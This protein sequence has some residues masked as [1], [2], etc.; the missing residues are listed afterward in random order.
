M[1]DSETRSVTLETYQ[2]DGCLVV[3][4]V[5]RMDEWMK[6]SEW[7]QDPDAVPEDELRWEAVEAEL[8]EGR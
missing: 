5:E 3:Q 6:S 1:S 8:E 2:A 4:T 7:V